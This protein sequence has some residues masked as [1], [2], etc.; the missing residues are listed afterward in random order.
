MDLMKIIQIVCGLLLVG[1][2]ILSAPTYYKEHTV[3]DKI[4]HKERVIKDSSSYYLIYGENETYK[5]EDSTVKWQFRSS[6]IYGHLEIGKTY[7]LTV[8]GFRYGYTSDYRNII[9]YN[10]SNSTF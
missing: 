4:I 2:I 6:D 7:N 5:L 10:I 9:G 8:Y 3:T 1:L